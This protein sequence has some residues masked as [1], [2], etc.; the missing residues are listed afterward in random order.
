MA[1]WVKICELSE[2]PQ[3]GKAM[4]VDAAGVGICLANVDGKLSA[5]DNWCPHRRG[6]LGQGWVEGESV[7]CP[8]HSWTFNVKTGEAEFPV[9]ER[10]A[11][12]PVRVEGEGVWVDAGT[13]SGNQ[14]G[15][16]G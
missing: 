4:E 3:A 6:P 16:T 7:V 13:A 8:W 1:Q 14:A 11:V 2:A 10:V 5:L 15:N 9:H 12:F